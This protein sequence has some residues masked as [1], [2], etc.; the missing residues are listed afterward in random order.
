MTKVIQNDY[1]KQVEPNTSYDFAKGI[2]F[3]A[4]DS[5][6]DV[7]FKISQ[8]GLKPRV[9]QEELGAEIV[10]ESALQS[11][12]GEWSYPERNTRVA[13]TFDSVIAL[14]KDYP[15]LLV[16]IKQD[17]VPTITNDGIV[18]LYLLVLEPAHRQI[19]LGYGA[20]IEAK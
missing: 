5:L 20:V 18:V 1:L 17:N 9:S 15:E 10:S 8:L 3:Y 14:A 11:K 7:N 12:L 4:S 2:E 6:T 16:R 19:L 13:L